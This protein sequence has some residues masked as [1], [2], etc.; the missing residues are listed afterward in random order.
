[1]PNFVPTV[2]DNQGTPD[3]S[4]FICHTTATTA[5]DGT[6]SVDITNVGFVNI[7]SVSAHVVSSDQTAGNAGYTSLSTVSTT[8]I[9]GRAVKPVTV[10]LAS[11]SVQAIGSGHTVYVTVI[12]N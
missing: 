12:G 3:T 1:M 6:W 11:L 7:F 5:S 9:A 4:P 10:V 2:C 8:T